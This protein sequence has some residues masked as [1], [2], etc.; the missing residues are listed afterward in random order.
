MRSKKNKRGKDKEKTITDTMV[1]TTWW[2][3]G[4]QC[5]F[6][7]FEVQWPAWTQVLISLG[8]VYMVK[9]MS[10]RNYGPAINV[11]MEL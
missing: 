4:L 1:E 5:S 6:T 7:Q 8:D 2:P 11:S 10:K 9:I 3:G